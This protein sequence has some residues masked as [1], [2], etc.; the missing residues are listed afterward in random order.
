MN[1]PELKYKSTAGANESASEKQFIFTEGLDALN[2]VEEQID[3]YGL[4][5]NK[6]YEKVE[7]Q[8]KKQITRNALT[9]MKGAVFA[10]GTRSLGNPEWKEHC[11]SSLREI[12]HEWGGIQEF[13]NDFAGIV[14]KN[15]GLA[16]HESNNLKSLWNLYAYFSGIDHHEASKVLRSLK[17]FLNDASLKPEDCYKDGVFID[18]V[19]DFFS[20]LSHI[21]AVPGQGKKESHESN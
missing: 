20:I 15:I 11:A 19:K 5:V 21:I 16:E 13:T 18:R 14:R 7:T 17:N 6:F 9:M 10:I 4:F 12:F 3:S 2:L 1:D 8:H